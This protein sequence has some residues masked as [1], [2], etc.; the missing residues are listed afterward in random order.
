MLTYLPYKLWM[1]SE[2]ASQHLAR[3]YKK[4]NISVA[5]WRVMSLIH[6]EHEISSIQISQK[7]LM[8]KSRVA[9][10][11]EKLIEEGN[12]ARSV[13]ELDK[14]AYIL[15][16]T[17]KGRALYKDIAK[18]AQHIHFRLVSSLSDQELQNVNIALIKFDG[19]LNGLEAEYQISEEDNE[20]S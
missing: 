13:N 17:E 14:R 8:D 2:R 5:Q 19:V 11:V 9:R 18:Q 3:Y 12:V 7:I 15:E 10:A 1:L 20:L 16:L 4:Q 6:S